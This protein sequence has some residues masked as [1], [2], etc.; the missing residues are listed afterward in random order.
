MLENLQTQASELVRGCVAQQHA[1]GLRKRGQRLGRASSE[2]AGSPRGQAEHAQQL[3]IAHQRDADERAYFGIGQGHVALVL[4]H[5][6]DFGRPA[7][8]GDPA[9][10]AEA[11]GEVRSNWRPGWHQSSHG[12]HFAVADHAQCTLIRGD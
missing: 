11:D 6:L 3:A 1:G 8:G 4:A 5:V 7:G 10:D 12:N 9:R 2:R